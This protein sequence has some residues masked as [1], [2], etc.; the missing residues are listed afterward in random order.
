MSDN[1]YARQQAEQ[2]YRNSP[3]TQHK[4]PLET[5][6]YEQRQ[7]HNNELDRQRQLEEERRRN[8]G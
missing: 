5:Q 6:T 4:Q 8:Q 7:A 2:D 3:Y 1:N